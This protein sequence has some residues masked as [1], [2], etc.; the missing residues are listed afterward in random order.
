VGFESDIASEVLVGAEKREALYFPKKETS[1]LAKN[2]NNLGNGNVIL[3]SGAFCGV[4]GVS[5]FSG[6]VVGGVAPFPLIHYSF[7][8]FARL[9]DRWSLISFLL[10]SCSPSLPSNYPHTHRAS[11][12]VL[13]SSL[14]PPLDPRHL[15]GHGCEGRWSF[16]PVPE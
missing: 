11:F 1:Q 14:P 9:C 16:A 6:F 15:L 7:L 8:I 2:K 12:L 5:T 10:P 13:P 4:F 3:N